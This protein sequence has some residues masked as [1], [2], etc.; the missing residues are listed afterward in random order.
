MRSRRLAFVF[1]VLPFAFYAY[2]CSSD[3]STSPSSD[4]AGGGSETGT[5]GEEDSSTP[6]EKDSSTPGDKDSSTPNDSGT[7]AADA[8]DGGDGGDAGDGGLDFCVGNPL[9]ADGGIVTGGYMVDASAP[10]QIFVETF[11]ASSFIDGPQWIEANGGQLVFSQ[12]Y[13]VPRATYTTGID[14]GTPVLFR[15]TPNDNVLPIG[16]AFAAD[17]GV[18]TTYSASGGAAGIARTQPNKTAN[19]T[20]PVAPATNP[21]DLVVGPKG[22]VYFT[23]PK[24]QTDNAGAGSGVYRIAPDGG[25]AAIDTYDQNN[26]QRMNGIALS[27]DNK[28]LYVSNTETKQILKYAVATDGTVAKPGTPVVTGTVD[29]PDGIAVDDAENIWVAEAH[30]TFGTQSGRVEVFTKA[31]VKLAEIPFPTQR[32]TSV[33]FGGADN[34]TVFVT[35]ERAIYVLATRCPGVR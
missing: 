34:K 31:G 12:V 1:A 28:T 3:D 35:T 23:D 33:A 16:N 14:G 29:L 26:V 24:F 5:T 2:A 19:S 9:L 4:D 25:V 18:L 8:G 13:G 32:P 27:P 10:R 7:D 15:Q 11:L 6:G 17:G 30:S 20:V 22:D 21:N